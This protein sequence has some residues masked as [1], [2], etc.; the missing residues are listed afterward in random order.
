M[1]LFEHET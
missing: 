1:N